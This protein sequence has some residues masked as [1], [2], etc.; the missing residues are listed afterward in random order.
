MFRRI[1]LVVLFAF[2]AAAVAAKKPEPKT[3]EVEV[4]VFENHLPNLEGGEQWAPQSGRPLDTAN[5][6]TPQTGLDPNSPM[7]AVVNRL[8]ANPTYRVLAVYHWTQTQDVTNPEPPPPAWVQ[9]AT[10]ALSGTV[11]FYV[12]RFLHVSVHLLLNST[13]PAT[14]AVA[15]D[16]APNVSV[17]PAT[18]PTAS[19]PAAPPVYV[20]DEERRVRTQDLNYFDHPKFGVIVRVTYLKNGASGE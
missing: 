2:S 20:I 14:P 10:G 3:Y 19:A 18:A 9:D 12:S 5:V 4:V 8:Q 15:P 7:Q 13:A 17:A 11:R 16:A 6:M 1:S